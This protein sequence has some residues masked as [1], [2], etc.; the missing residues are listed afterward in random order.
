ML[1]PRWYLLANAS[2][3]GA[4]VTAKSQPPAS[5]IDLLWARPDELFAN[6]YNPN[7]LDEDLYAKAVN[8]IANYGFVD[9]VTVR[10]R[11]DGGY[12]IIDGEHRVRA[13]RELG[14]RLVPIIVVEAD[15]DTAQQ[16]TLVLNELRGRP[17][18]QR[19]QR[20]L[21]GLAERHSIENLL[22]TLPFAREQFAPAAAF[23]RPS[24]PPNGAAPELSAW[25]ERM[26]RLPRSAADILDQAL[27][28]A[29]EY[30]EVNED[31]KALEAIARRY[32]E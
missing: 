14:L 2:T 25:V 31:W 8:S 13:A 10:K 6:L 26:Y 11:A 24:L 20:I 29:K 18:R 28:E 16:L 4:S 23:S 5:E 12:E 27:E 3:G 17:D 32:I 7:V 21:T 19:L 15:D 22:Q 1:P 9:P 30:E